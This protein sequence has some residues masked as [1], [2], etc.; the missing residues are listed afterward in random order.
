MLL[1]LL[2]SSSA[3]AQATASANSMPPWTVLAL[4][5][6]SATHVQPTTGIVLAAPD[7]VLVAM[8]FAR[9][10][11]EI[12][13]LDGGTDIV[14]HGRPATIIHTLPADK[15]AILKVQGL[16]RPAAS[17]SALSEAEHK[18]LNL[19]AFPPAE[20]IAQ[21]AAPVRSSVKALPA[22][23]TTHP[24]L[25]PFPN[26]SGALTDTCGNLVAFNLAVSVQ[27]MQPTASPR[28]VWP[29]ALKR[30]AELA[31]TPLRISPCSAAEAKEPE[32]VTAAVEPEPSP[33]DAP[34]TEPAA[35]EV[36]ADQEQDLAEEDQVAADGSLDF[37]QLDEEI[38]DELA[39]E[40]D[41]DAEIDPVAAQA[42]GIENADDAET[43]GGQARKFS[44]AAR[45]LSFL[46]LALILAWWLYRQRAKRNNGK[47]ANAGSR[48]DPRMTEAGP[49][50]PAT[51]RFDTAL[52]QAGLI[53]LQLQGQLPD[54]ESFSQQLPIG[55]SDWQAE[56]GRQDADIELASA[57]ISR[58]HAR[59]QIH[60]G[61]ITI[62]DLGSTNG[63][64]LNG[65][66]CL[67]DEVF[68]VQSSDELQLGD[69]IFKLQLSAG[70][71]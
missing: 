5:L 4:K 51:V 60:D 31:G 28:L 10:G 64:R 52:Q 70:D 65:V 16:S 49:G 66:P 8:D 58:R 54:G 7:L 12:M 68:F 40:T 44:V 15:L 35:V 23:T 43:A 46:A 59:I 19:V 33:A 71:D 67:P 45:L 27:S 25:D 69:V 30:A 2:L 24:T 50:E 48:R 57:T 22:I 13:V 9:E 17:L 36:A 61:R 34:K 32:P 29:D 3:G 62:S 47:T 38:T 53:H 56:I 11:D 26:V 20:A 41:T 6:V 63:T 37:E 14:R 55:D 1:A 42:D 18:T 21:G 39:A